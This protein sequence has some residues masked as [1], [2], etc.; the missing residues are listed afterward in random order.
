MSIDAHVSDADLRLLSV[1][2]LAELLELSTRQ[3]RRLDSTGKIPQPHR[4]GR[5]VR[6]R[7]AEILAWQNAGMPEREAWEIIKPG[8]PRP[9]QWSDGAL[10]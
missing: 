4:L 7:R 9:S 5:S 10:D 1:A 3:V 6:W 8:D 2:S